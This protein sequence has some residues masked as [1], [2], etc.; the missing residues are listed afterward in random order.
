MNLLYIK[1]GFHKFNNYKV[2]KSS[3]TIN[4][5]IYKNLFFF[6]DFSDCEYQLNKVNNYKIYEEKRNLEE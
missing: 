3:S 6:Y 5:F 2:V 1:S 4:K